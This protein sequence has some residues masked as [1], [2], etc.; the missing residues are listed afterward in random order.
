MLAAIKGSWHDYS[1]GILRGDWA[2]AAA[3]YKRQFSK[4][5]G[6]GPDPAQNYPAGLL[7][8]DELGSVGGKGY[9]QNHIDLA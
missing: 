1:G 4:L 9:I 3:D 5:R 6:F 7:T 8:L 2:L